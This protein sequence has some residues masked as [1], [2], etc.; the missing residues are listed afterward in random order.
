MPWGHPPLPVTT[1]K[2]EYC[3]TKI[4]SG[5]ASDS[6]WWSFKNRHNAHD[7]L[8]RLETKQSQNTLADQE[9]AYCGIF[10]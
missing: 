4:V 7:E 9:H 6:S 8:G 2:L 10:L 5:T 3:S 1:D